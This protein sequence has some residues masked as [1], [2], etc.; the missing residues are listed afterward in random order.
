M[1]SFPLPKAAAWGRRLMG[2]TISKPGT[3]GDAAL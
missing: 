3:N 2:P 1:R